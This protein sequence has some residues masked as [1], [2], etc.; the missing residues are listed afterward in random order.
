QS[1][2]G[3]SAPMTAS[4]TPPRRGVSA[5]SVVPG[6]AAIS[7]P[8]RPARVA[9]RVARRRA[10]SAICY[11]QRT[12]AVGCIE[13]T[14]EVAG[15]YQAGTTLSTRAPCQYPGVLRLQ[16]YGFPDSLVIEDHHAKRL[17]GGQ[18]AGRALQTCPSGDHLLGIPVT[19]L[20]PVLP[21]RGQLQVERAG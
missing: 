18:L 5:A 12:R 1:R 2:L 16:F 15:R 21:Q 19:E 20:A 4:R 13:R 10:S 9:K 11:L 14:S 17:R 8:Q 6:T 7:E 3:A